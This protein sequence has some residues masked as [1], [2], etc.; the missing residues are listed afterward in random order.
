MKARQPTY[1]F[2]L[3]L[4]PHEDE[5]RAA[6]IEAMVGPVLKTH[7]TVNFQIFW[8]IFETLFDKAPKP[9]RA[10][11][12]KQVRRLF[13]AGYSKYTRHEIFAAHPWLVPVA[14]AAR[15]TPIMVD[16]GYIFS[17]ARFHTEGLPHL[18]AHE[19]KW[20]ED[21]GVKFSERK[22]GA[23][24]E[25]KVLYVPRKQRLDYSDVDGRVCK[26]YVP[27]LLM[28]GHQGT[29]R[30]VFTR[31]THLGVES[32]TVISKEFLYK[33]IGAEVG[34]QKKEVLRGKPLEGLEPTARLV[35]NETWHPPE[36]PRDPNEIA[37]TYKQNAP[38]QLG[39]FSLPKPR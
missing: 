33:R 28:K 14:I 4:Q 30:E 6:R 34:E 10:D 31:A 18:T 1:P 15:T 26:A 32:L 36:A 37:K 29:Y 24:G 23:K 13:D 38:F 35:Q 19:K 21:R 39:L 11:I 9:A 2:D 5:R 12:Q 3:Y 22:H 17:Q 27:S 8:S 7:E 25:E 20:C 16:N